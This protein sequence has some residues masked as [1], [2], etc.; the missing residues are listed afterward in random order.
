M[1]RQNFNFRSNRIPWEEW[2]NRPIE[3]L[4]VGN[5]YWPSWVRERILRRDQYTCQLC[6]KHL[7]PTRLLVHH[8]EYCNF[9]NTKA[10][11]TLCNRCHTKINWILRLVED[12]IEAGFL[13]QDDIQGLD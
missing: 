12:A 9:V 5:H 7:P 3:G 2:I 4:P 10:L 1:E 11:I 13:K 8:K 6:H